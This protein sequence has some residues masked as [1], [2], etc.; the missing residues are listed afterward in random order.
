MHAS[1]RHCMLGFVLTLGKSA[2]SLE[3]GVECR[4][5]QSFPNAAGDLRHAI[6][7]A[8][9]GFLIVKKLSVVA[10]A[11]RQQT[12]SPLQGWPRPG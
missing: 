9:H 3:L 5:R 11:G 2:L 12:E 1:Y 10:R 8:E 7:E 4:R 6:G